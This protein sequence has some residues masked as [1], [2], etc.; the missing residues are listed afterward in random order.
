MKVLLINGSPNEFGCT[1]TALK[2]VSDKL[3]EHGIETEIFQIGKKPVPGCID[4]GYCSKNGKCAFPDIAGILDHAEEYDGIV[5]GS[6]VYFAGPSGQVCS[7]LDRLFHSS[8]N[9]WAGKFAAAVV[10]CRRAGSTASFDRLNKYFTILNMNVVGSSYWN[11][12]HGN[13]PDEVKRDLE[14]MRCLRTLGE[15][16]AYLIKCVDAGKKAGV[17]LPQYEP[18]VRTNFIR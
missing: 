4:C 11:Q 8:K 2:E 15:N 10:S 3:K 13:T 6:P 16:M 7:L 1:Y 14:G 9:K 17:P 5:V 12:V 18:P